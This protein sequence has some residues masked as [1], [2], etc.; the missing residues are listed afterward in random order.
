MRRK[1]EENVKKKI[2]SASLR[3]HK[4]EFVSK[5]VHSNEGRVKTTQKEKVPS[6]EVRKKVC[7]VIVSDG[8][9]IM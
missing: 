8:P 7:E 4:G 2:N 1:P 6:Q 9:G 5:R 3:H